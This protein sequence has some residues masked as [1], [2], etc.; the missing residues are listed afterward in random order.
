[1][2]RLYLIRH[3]KAGH[4]GKSILGDFDRELTDKGH[5]MCTNIVSFLKENSYPKPEIIF[6]S[7][8]KRTHQT[9]SNV[10]NHLGSEIESIKSLYL[11]S[12]SEILK[13][14]NS[15]DDSY[16]NIAIIG[17]N[18]G[19]AQLA[20]DIAGA[21]NKTAYRE[22]RNKFSPP[23]VAVFDIPIKTWAE[24]DNKKGKLINF[25]NCKS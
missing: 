11:A 4:G 5:Q 17:H 9:A 3:S 22:M 8:A 16:K 6:H 20:I 7:A 23:S 14:I 15:V 24:L 21:G 2:K 1:M 18:P 10:N 12:E 13:F 25:S 19:L